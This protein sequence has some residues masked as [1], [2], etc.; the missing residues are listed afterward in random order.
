MTKVKVKRTKQAQA[1]K[2]VADFVLEEVLSDIGDGRSPVSNGNWKRSLSKSY[3]PIKAKR[4]S[5]GF[6]NLELSGN[7]LDSLE[8]RTRDGS[9]KLSLQVEGAQA[10]KADGNNR[11]TYG[12]SRA[13]LSRAREFI[14]RGRKSLKKD[15]REGI[16]RVLKEFKDEDNVNDQAES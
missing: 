11:G 14:P 4:S 10:A 3:K 8:V 6:A 13:N 1:R 12:S 7:M 2:A 15:I 16:A 9:N 5:A